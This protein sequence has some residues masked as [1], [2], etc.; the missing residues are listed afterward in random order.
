[1]FEVPSYLIQLTYHPDVLAG[2]VK[3]PT[4]RSE[5][6]RKLAVKM[7][8]TLVGSWISFGDYDAVIVIEGADLVSAA[9]CSMAV[10]ASGA[11]KSFKTTPML[12]I[13]EAMAAMKKAGTLGYK[14]P[15]GKKK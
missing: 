3:H 1:V 4:D 9:A 14:P 8:G 12:N 7:G 2:F 13:D 5:V 15:S 11:F 6:I 10:S